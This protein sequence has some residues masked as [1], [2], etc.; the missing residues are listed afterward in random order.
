MGKLLILV[1]VA[2][3]AYLLWRGLRRDAE[4][5][6]DTAG[7]RRADGRLQPVRRTPA[8]LRGGRG[9]R[10]GTSA[11]TSTA[12]CSALEQ[13]RRPRACGVPAAGPGARPREP[14][15]V[16]DSFWVSLRYFNAYRI[17]IAVLFLASALVYGDALNLGS[18]DLRLFTAAAA[19]YL[20]AAVAFQVALKRV[21]RSFDTHLTAHVCTDIAAT[22]LLMFASGG[23]R[24]GLAVMLLISIAAASLVSRGRLLLFYAAL[25][26]I[27]VLLEQAVEVVAFGESLGGFLPAGDDLDRLLRHRARHQPARAAGDHQ[28]AGRTAA[29]DRPRQPAADQPARDPGRAGRRAGRRLERPRAQPQPAGRAAARPAGARARPDRGVL[30]RAR[31]GAR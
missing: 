4:P 30:G 20:A 12:G 15:A 27:A 23:F 29:R 25:A 2:L 11:P 16:P 5:R 10:A 24:S 8:G 6:R 3:V 1:L 13:A 17:A 18:H 14:H 22:V 21:P 19:A 26:T 31:P 7:R 9:A 28:R